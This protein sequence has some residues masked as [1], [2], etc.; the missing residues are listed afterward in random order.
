MRPGGAN[1]T[2]LG[3]ALRARA[4]GDADARPLSRQGLPV[5]EPDAVPDDAIHRGAY[6]LRE[7]YKDGEP[8]PD[9]DRHRLR[10]AHLHRGGRA[11]RG[12][13]GIATRVVSAPCLDRFAEQDEDY[14][15]TVLPPSVPR[16]RLGRGGLATSAGERWTGE[17]GDSIGMTTFG[18]SAPQPDLY[19]HFGFT[20]RRSPPGR[21]ER[22]SARRRLRGGLMSVGA[23]STSGSRR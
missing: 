10:G 15:D 8:G 17:D 20:P 18:A 2:A 12:G 22:A 19:E 4:D 6:V 5:L 11:A 14:R 23:R 16:A 21:V 13:R 1:E 7:S 9:P 3:L